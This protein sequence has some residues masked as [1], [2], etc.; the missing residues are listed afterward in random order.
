MCSPRERQVAISEVQEAGGRRHAPG[1][2][3]RA[4]RRVRCHSE[5]AR[6]GEERNRG[7]DVLGRYRPEAAGCIRPAELGLQV[8]KTVEVNCGGRG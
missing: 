4:A 3:Q 5:C 7:H 2:G 1:R 6:Q 8:R